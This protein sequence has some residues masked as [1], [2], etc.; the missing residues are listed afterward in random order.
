MAE[1]NSIQPTVGYCDYYQRSMAKYQRGLK[2][3]LGGTGN[4]KTSGIRK[5]VPTLTVNDR[6]LIYCANRV[7]LVHEM[8]EQLPKG[9]YVHLPSDLDSVRA[10][11]NGEG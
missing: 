5:L 2:R 11:L 1:Q 3:V 6:K 8:A 10:L 9:S 7:Q 4:G